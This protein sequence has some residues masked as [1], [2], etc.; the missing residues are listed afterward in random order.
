MSPIKQLFKTRNDFHFALFLIVT[1]TDG[2]KVQRA[3]AT[4][5]LIHRLIHRDDVTLA[6]I[7]SSNGF[8]FALE[9]NHFSALIMKASCETKLTEIGVWVFWG[10]SLV[11]SLIE[12]ARV[13]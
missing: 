12:F 10:H 5:R 6:L 2:E 11:R 4:L 8:V 3:D 1:L 7:N 9:A 13:P